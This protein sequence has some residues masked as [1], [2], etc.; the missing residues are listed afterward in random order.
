[1]TP[2]LQTKVLSRLSRFTSSSSPSVQK[3]SS[4]F[5]F[6]T[7]FKENPNFTVPLVFSRGFEPQYRNKLA[8]TDHTGQHFT[9]GD[10]TKKALNLAKDI[11]TLLP[12]SQERVAFLCD[13]DISF[14]VTLGATWW[15]Q[16][17]GN[18]Q[19]V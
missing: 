2:P 16:Q 12:E 3:L 8:F 19:T 10:L 5:N 1:M 6:E 14:P 18:I 13:R 9:F 15:A 11:K 4:Q 17:I 7:C